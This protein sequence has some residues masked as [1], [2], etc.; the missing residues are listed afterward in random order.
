VG[1]D[2]DVADFGEVSGHANSLR[3]EG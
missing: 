2:A 3:Q 1:D